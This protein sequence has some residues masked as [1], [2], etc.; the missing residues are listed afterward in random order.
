MSDA[1]KTD[2]E[3]VGA[4]WIMSDLYA[5]QAITQ[6]AFA[7]LENETSDEAAAVVVLMSHARNLL[8]KIINDVDNDFAL[9]A[10]AARQAARRLPNE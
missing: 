1:K 10:A 8:A 4:Q 3:L 9:L 6:G 5:V 7:L 2:V